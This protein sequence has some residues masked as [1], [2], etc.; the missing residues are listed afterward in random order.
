[1]TKCLSVRCVGGGE[2]SNNMC[3][4]CKHQGF[5]PKP[6]LFLKVHYILW[7]HVCRL[8]YCLSFKTFQRLVW[9][10]FLY[11]FS[12]LRI[13]QYPSPKLNP[14]HQKI[15][16]PCSFMNHAILSK[17]RHG[18]STFEDFVD[19]ICGWWCC[20][21]HS[22]WRDFIKNIIQVIIITSCL[23]KIV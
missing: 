1:M 15:H 13:D 17:F 5:T 8:Y 4:I 6:T 7:W 23:R 16:T 3:V 14:A 20:S 12:S 18:P 2:L 11:S 10:Y 22:S 21:M 9:W 19:E